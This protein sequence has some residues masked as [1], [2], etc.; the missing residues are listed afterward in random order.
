MTEHGKHKKR[1]RGVHKN[2][3]SP[4]MRFRNLASPT[5]VVASIHD[6]CSGMRCSA[7]QRSVSGLEA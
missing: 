3:G 4:S 5:Y 1:K 6:G 2:A 7:F